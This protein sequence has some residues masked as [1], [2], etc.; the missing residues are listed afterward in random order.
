MVTETV[1]GTRPRLALVDGFGLIFRAYHALPPTMATKSGE[2]TNAV[3]GFAS[4]LLDVIRLHHPEY[5]AVALEG[6]RTFRH[7]SFEGYKANRAEAPDD[8]V[9]QIGRVKELIETLNFP[10]FQQPGYEADDV[11]GSLSRSCAASGMDVTIVTGDSDLLQLVD[12]HVVAVLPGA[13][14]FGEFRFYDVPAVIERYG[15]GP[16]LIPDYKA[17]VGDTSDNIP[18]VPGIGEKTAKALI[19][20]F[21]SLEEIVSHI[22]D[23]TPAR[24]QKALSENI[25][26]AESSKVLATIIRDLD[27]PFKMGEAKVST[28]DRDAVVSLFQTLEFRTL[29]N[30]LP[31]TDG[32]HRHNGG[33]GEVMPV[34]ERAPSDRTLVDEA[35]ELAHVA[36]RIDKTGVYAID[37]ETTSV[38]PM[39]ADLVG[40]AI[41]VSPTEAYYIPVGHAEWSNLTVDVIK[42]AIG[43]S[44]A[45]PANH[46]YAHHGKYDIQVLE[47]HGF[48]IG[49]L[50][51]DTMIAAFLLGETSIRL[52][53]LAFNR[54]GI[55]MTEISE[56]IGAGKNQLTMNMVSADQAAQYASGDVEATFAL[57]D[58]LRPQIEAQN[59]SR[60]LH[61]IELPLVPV[62]V[63]MERNGVA[64]DLDFLKALSEEI[65][66]RFQQ[67]EQEI[68]GIVGRAFNIN[69]T[70]QLAT[71]LFEELNLPSGKR[72]KTG[73]SVDSD[74]LEALRDAHPIVP[75]ILEYRTLGK[76][77]STYV[78]A[79][80]LQVNPNTGR[81]HTNYNMTV[82]ATGRLSSVNPNLQNIPIRTELG[83]RVREAFV[84]DHRPQY[85][86]FDD[87]VLVGADYSQIELRLMAHMSGE[88]FLVEAFRAGQDI[89][90]ATAAL[91]Y[92]VAPSEVTSDMRRVAKT[93]N[94]GLLYGMQAFGL[95]RDTGLSRA[96]AT[97]FIEQYWSRLPRVRSL[98]D[99]I[100]QFG[101]T[102]GYVETM[103]GRRRSVPDLTSTNGARRAAAER[104]AQNMPLQGSAA[105]IMK[106]AMIKL[107][108]R[109]RQEKQPA[110]IILQ[111]H[112]ELVLEVDK[113]AVNDVARLLKEVMESAWDL[114]VPLVADVSTGQNWN[115]ME[116]SSV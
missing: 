98:F 8:L 24:A 85:R 31:E 105:D 37:V 4:M 95:S 71:L 32:Q 109:L 70:K 34:V 114:S 6:G 53:D 52:K 5:I 33:N 86:Y 42:Q 96:E 102:H 2:Q 26:S 91:V 88:P 58:D 30:K 87:A 11:I 12:E 83:R 113:P 78:D 7:E 74:V 101:V 77:K 93:V 106:I 25:E 81:I 47:R 100:L 36:K 19:E 89:H 67:I 9:Q 43:P 111:V 60:L 112:D 54:L 21:G 110:R 73:Y 62:L 80:P 76:L 38:D 20:R 115:A 97:K 90:A 116:E 10:I 107:D 108:Q 18:G 13:R 1:E 3:Y 82:A 94:F 57:V 72:T 51:F 17:L 41:A 103:S 40:I 22:K 104:V 50:E 59:Q 44:L 27:V 28:Y 48:E 55:Q 79:L 75:L 45:N 66:A 35:S 23:V 68:Y 29:I 64:V 46:A 92:G 39:M 65:T 16:D 14:R 61:D 99:E 69:S 63:R 84:A 49:N 56:L 15:F